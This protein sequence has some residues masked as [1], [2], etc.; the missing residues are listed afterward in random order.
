[1][2][3]KPIGFGQTIPTKCPHFQ[4]FLFM[5]VFVQLYTLGA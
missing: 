3:P 5:K 2:K 4:D 1:M